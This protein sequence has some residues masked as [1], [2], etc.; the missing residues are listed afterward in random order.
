MDLFCGRVTIGDWRY[1]GG[2]LL[3]FGK[4]VTVAAVVGQV[5]YD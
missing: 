2:F 5:E 3:G 4:R 1:V